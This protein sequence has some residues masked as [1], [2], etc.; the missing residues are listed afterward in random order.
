MKKS[1][2]DI[3]VALCEG[4]IETL[5]KETL[6]EF[7]RVEPMPSQN[8]AYYARYKQAQNRIA[9]ALARFDE[10]EK[11]RDEEARYVK[12]LSVAYKSN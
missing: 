2:H 1:W 8:P 3:E 11:S 12:T 10:E 6:L 7:A 9:R 5:D 4:A